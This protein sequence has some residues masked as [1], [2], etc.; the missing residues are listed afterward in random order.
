MSPILDS[1]VAEEERQREAELRKQ[2]EERQRQAEEHQRLAEQERDQGRE[3]TRQTTFAELIHFCHVYFSR[4]LR[5]ERKIPAPTGKRSEQQKVYHSVCAYL[6]LSSQPARV[7]NSEQDLESYK[8]FSVEDYIY[9]IIIKLYKIPAAREEFCL[10]DAD[11]SQTDKSSSS[12]CFRPDQYCIY[13]IDNNNNIIIIIVE[14]K[15]PH[16]LSVKNLQAGL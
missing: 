2:A 3:K 11:Q 14:Y 8:Q 10:V 6:I 16:K 7:I 13:C 12:G 4:S 9:N 5:A 15:P 1:L